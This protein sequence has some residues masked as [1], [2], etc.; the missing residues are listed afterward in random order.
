MSPVVKKKP[1]KKS[2][3]GKYLLLIVTILCLAL[4]LLTFT[5]DISSGFLDSAV[6]TV[7]VPFQKG[8]MH[9]GTALTSI[10]DKRREY[11]ELEAENESLKQQIAELTSE[12][13][14][15][16]QDHYE[17]MSLREL[18]DLDN[19]YSE[20]EKTGARIIAADSGSWFSTFVIDKG[21]ADGVETDMNVISGAG[22]VGIVTETGKDWARVRTVIDDR[23]NVSATILH[24][25]DNLMIS[26]GIELI[27]QG[28]ISYSGLYDQD[29]NVREGD[30]VVTSGISSKY[31][32]GILIG[33]VESIDTDSNN[34]TRSGYITPVVDFEHLREVL[35]IL[36][37]KQN[38][39]EH[40]S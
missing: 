14:L 6:G 2:I 9:T 10:A 18:Y 30:K 25:G 15:L 5:T 27:E 40:G 37:K 24:T 32:P 34:M 36:E 7:V 29:E 26:G 17:L 12:N 22:L 20:Y 23:S 1:E 38:T 4:M 16:M 28:L 11:S 31:L 19:T 21:E 35:V 13:T 3:P 33:Y 39:G 8:L